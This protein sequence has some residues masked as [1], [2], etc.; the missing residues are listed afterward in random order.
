MNP[1][2]FSIPLLTST[3]KQTTEYSTF[4][5]LFTL[6]NDQAWGML[7]YE[8]PGKLLSMKAGVRLCLNGMTEEVLL[9]GVQ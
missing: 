9:Q 4:T 3:D 1:G 7:S 8:V 5:E 2:H 6:A